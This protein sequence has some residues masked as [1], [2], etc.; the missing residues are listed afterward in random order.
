MPLHTLNASTGCGISDNGIKH[1]PLHTL[2]AF[3][4]NKITDEGLKV[5]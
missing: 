5:L 1:L 2:N 4:N 3:C